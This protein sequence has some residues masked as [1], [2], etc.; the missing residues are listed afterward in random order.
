M[1]SLIAHAYLRKRPELWDQ[2]TFPHIHL[3]AH[4]R[5]CAHGRIFRSKVE[6]YPTTSERRVGRPG[7]E[8]GG[9]VAKP[10]LGRCEKGPSPSHARSEGARTQLSAPLL[11]KLRDSRETLHGIALH[12]TMMEIETRAN[13]RSG[14]IA[15]WPKCLNTRANESLGRGP[16]DER[17][18]IKE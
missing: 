18:P 15:R 6:G 7:G 9:L 3:L 1:L 14:E 2:S 4:L 12:L 13:A 11:C 5:F 16:A 17:K 10:G 8:K